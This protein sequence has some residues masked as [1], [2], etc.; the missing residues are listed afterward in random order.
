MNHNKNT[1][2]KEE[3]NNQVEDEKTTS[4]NNDDAQSNESTSIDEKDSS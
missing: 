3:V 4:V 1:D 2:N